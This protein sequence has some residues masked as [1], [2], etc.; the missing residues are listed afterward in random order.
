M[1]I[2]GR[3][4]KRPDGLVYRN[5]RRTRIADRT[6]LEGAPTRRGMVKMFL[7]TLREFA[8]LIKNRGKAQSREKEHG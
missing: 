8:Q 6:L 3:R 7:E 1:A 4:P 2:Q 5:M